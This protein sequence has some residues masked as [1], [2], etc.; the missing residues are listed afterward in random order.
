M[1]NN[2]IKHLTKK[3]IGNFLKNSIEDIREYVNCKTEVKQT[4]NYIYGAFVKRF[5]HTH[6]NDF[7]EESFALENWNVTVNINNFDRLGGALLYAKEKILKFQN[8]KIKNYL[9]DHSD[10]HKEN[11]SIHQLCDWE[12]LRD[13]NGDVYFSETGKNKEVVFVKYA[14]I[15]KDITNEFYSM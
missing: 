10:E 5:T 4:S 1:I 8:E 14:K 15:L 11:I 12:I 13:D 6:G 2:Y 3:E 7:E 9:A